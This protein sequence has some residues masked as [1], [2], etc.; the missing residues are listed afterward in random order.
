[1]PNQPILIHC[2][3][4]GTFPNSQLPVILY[5]GIL[6]IPLLMPAQFVKGLF[7]QNNWSNSWD[8]GIFTY[9]HYHSNTHEVLGVYKGSTLIQLGGGNG[10]QIK[11]EKGDVIIIPAGVALKN[12][13]HEDQIHCIGAYPEGHEYDLYTGRLGERPQ[14]DKHIAKVPLP[15]KDPVFG[16]TEGLPR[17]WPEA[18]IPGTPVRT[19]SPE[20]V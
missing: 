6:D 17:I 5:K 2:E 9:H 10:R 7:D 15:A 8:N 3:D 14:S 20:E 1:M 4:N 18:S 19:I 12:L 11:L 13:G 16:L